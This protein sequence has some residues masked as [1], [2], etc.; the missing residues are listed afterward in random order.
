MHQVVKKETQRVLVRFL[1]T[2]G[3]FRRV[4]CPGLLSRFVSDTRQNETVDNSEKEYLYYKPY[5]T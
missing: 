3:R 4:P 1:W 2:G 5:C